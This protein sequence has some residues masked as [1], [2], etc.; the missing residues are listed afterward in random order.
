MIVKSYIFC[1]LFLAQYFF[2]PK[3]NFKEPP[4]F[5]LSPLCGLPFRISPSIGF[6]KDLSQKAAKIT[7]NYPSRP[8]SGVSASPAAGASSPNQDHP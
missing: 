6:K 5:Q 3:K 1:L 4:T 2:F 7:K 8:G